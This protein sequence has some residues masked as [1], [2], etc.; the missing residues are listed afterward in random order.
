MHTDIINSQGSFTDAIEIGTLSGGVTI[1]ASPTASVYKMPASSG[2][3]SLPLEGKNVVVFGDSLIG[4]YRGDTSATTHLATVTGATVYN[5]GFG[6]CRMST[7]PTHGYAE[8][9]MWALADAVATGT[10]TSQ[11]QYVSQGSD[12]FHVD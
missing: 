12:Y 2:G 7:H 3:A 11:D 10:W 1:S 5:V 6:G 9:S 8:F 4:L